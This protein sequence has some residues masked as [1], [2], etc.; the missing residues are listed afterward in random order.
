MRRENELL[1]LLEEF[2]GIIP[3]MSRELT[4][5]HG[6][7]LASL[8]ATGQPASAPV[9]TLMDKRT[10]TASF[11]NLANR[12]MVKLLKTVI[13]THTGVTRPIVIAHLIDLDQEK[14]NTCLREISRT[15]ALPPIIVPVGKKLDEN[16]EFTASDRPTAARTSFSVS[17]A[18][19]TGEEVGE[20]LKDLDL[21]KKFFSADEE[22]IRESLLTER[23]TYSQIYGFITSKPLRCRQLHLILAEALE[24][25]RPS[26]FILSHSERIFHISHLFTAITL[27]QYCSLISPIQADDVLT[28]HFFDA[29]GRDMLLSDTPTN[30]RDLIQVGR[31]RPKTRLLDMLAVLCALKIVTPLVPAG[32]D[33]AHATCTP[34]GEHPS[35]FAVHTEDWVKGGNVVVANSPA[36]WQLNTSLPVYY[37][38]SAEVQPPLWKTLSVTNGAAV[39]DFWVELQAASRRKDLLV[40]EQESLRVLSTPVDQSVRHALTQRHTWDP[41]YSFSWHQR[42]FLSQFVH[43][44]SGDT[45]LQDASTKEER[46]KHLAYITSAPV[47]AIEDHFVKAQQLALK[48]VHRAKKDAKRLELARESS[49]AKASLVKMATA[50]QTERANHWQRLVTNVHPEEYDHVA[51]IRLQRLRN[52]FMKASTQ[53]DEEWEKDITQAFEDAATA[54]QRVLKRKSNQAKSLFKPTLPDAPLYAFEDEDAMIASDLLPELP[55]LVSNP[56]EKDLREL[57]SAQGPPLP[58]PDNKRK[59]AD[60]KP[61]KS[62]CTPSRFL[63]T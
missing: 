48:E 3:T 31:S 51:D 25:Q 23:S 62:A 32:P 20:N 35:S 59:R 18:R 34:S 33:G 55:P 60:E 28:Q 11:N 57:I 14:I 53:T 42:Q 43:P 5:A 41:G 9:G 37:W 17:L 26:D 39:T 7:L 30:I 38:A 16:I 29:G 12:G 21:A 47:A 2:G 1:Q 19:I 50:A 27:G 56:Q 63:L 54:S 61:S 8:A 49:K 4:E 13:A 40:V 46:L 15:A 22:Q 24:G 6:N 44:S 36:Y 58:A 45:P 52:N 10:V